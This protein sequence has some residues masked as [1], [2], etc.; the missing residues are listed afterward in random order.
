M[1][2]RIYG[3]F[4]SF[5]RPD[6]PV[7]RYLLLRE[8]RRAGRGTTFLRFLG[9]MIILGLLGAV[10][11]LISTEFGRSTLSPINPH[12]NIYLILYWPLV[13][14]QVILHVLAF[15]GTVGVVAAEKR[16]GT[17]DTLKITTEG[18]LLTIKA[19]WATTFYRLWMLLCVLTAARVIFI[20]VA[21]INISAYQ[22]GYIDNMISGTIPLGAES[23]GKDSGLLGAILIL[24]MMMTGTVLAPFTAVAFDAALGALVG[25]FARGKI[26][27]VLGQIGVILLRLMLTAWALWI[28]S[29]ALG[30]SPFI[31]QGAMTVPG[32]TEPQVMNWMGALL[33]IAEGDMGLTLLH[34]PHVQ[35]LWADIPYGVFAGV[36]FLG[37]I[38]LQAGLANVMVW[39]AGRRVLRAE[40]L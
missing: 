39:W 16:L 1:L 10:G 27:G 15:N 20:G 32:L 19:R 5:A 12:E 14:L 30:L 8:G 36:A 26:G 17:W 29:L 24:A 28:G 40:R 2:K 22:G 9:L 35:R 18:A 31:G 38:L 34:L 25:T 7:M 13:I 21:L 37:Y 3:Q 4:P 11:Y 6:H 23:L 33:G